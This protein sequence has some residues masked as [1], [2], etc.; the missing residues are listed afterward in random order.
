MLEFFDEASQTE[1]GP[2]EARSVMTGYDPTRPFA[3]AWKRAS[4]ISGIS[5]HHWS[6]ETDSRT[7][8]AGE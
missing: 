7:E 4:V 8:R 2:F 3:V 1:G 6:R 5:N